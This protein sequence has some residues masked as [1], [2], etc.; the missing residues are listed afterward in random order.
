MK[1]CDIRKIIGRRE[2]I[3]KEVRNLIAQIGVEKTKTDEIIKRKAAM[4]GKRKVIIGIN[5]SNR[6]F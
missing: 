1:S 5:K 4:T 6:Y 2:V 3:L